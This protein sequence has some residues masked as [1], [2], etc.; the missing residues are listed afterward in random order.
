MTYYQQTKRLEPAGR[1][2]WKA[3]IQC[4]PEGYETWIPRGTPILFTG[5]GTYR[6]AENEAAMNILR[7]YLNDRK[8]G[9]FLI[10]MCM[11]TRKTIAGNKSEQVFI[12]ITERD[13]S[14]G[15]KKK[16]IILKPIQAQANEGVILD[17]QGMLFQ[18]YT[19][20][21]TFNMGIPSDELFSTRNHICIDGFDTQHTKRR[22]LDQ[23]LT[24][25]EPE[26]LRYIYTSKSKDK[27]TFS[28]CLAEGITTNYITEELFA[29]MEAVGYSIAAKAYGMLPGRSDVEWLR[30]IRESATWSTPTPG[31]T[32]AGRGA[33]HPLR[34]ANTPVSTMKPSTSST[35]HTQDDGF[36]LA[37]RKR[38]TETYS[39]ILTQSQ[40][41]LDG[42]SLTSAAGGLNSASLNE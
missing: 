29:G 24:R 9:P 19:E 40:P 3:S 32:N 16:D 28:V 15:N 12:A 38:T 35:P 39:D 5:T 26:H 6:T 36:R 1:P 14:T 10:Y 17:T 13:N 23:I 20:P 30:Y 31:K 34:N 41:S 2:T 27:T 8:I 37:H 25:M 22:I 21:G 18:L 7:Q 11:H 33:A 4:I 42:S